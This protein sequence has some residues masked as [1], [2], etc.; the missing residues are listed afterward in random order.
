MS[1]E[2]L[3]GYLDRL[4]QIRR[5]IFD[6]WQASLRRYNGVVNLPSFGKCYTSRVAEGMAACRPVVSWKVPDRPRNLRLFESDHEILLYDQD[7]ANTLSEHLTRLARDPDF[8]A[9]L[10]KMP[11]TGSGKSTPWKNALQIS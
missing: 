1:Q 7:D 3:T 6:H 10:P 4:R 8:P 11:G 5:N 9:A 2:D